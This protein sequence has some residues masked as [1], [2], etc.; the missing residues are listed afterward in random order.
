MLYLLD[1]CVLITANNTYYPIDQVPE[2]WDWLL[3]QSS[4]GRIKM[5]VE[6]LEEVLN[7]K[8]ESD[9]LVSWLSSCEYKTKLLLPNEEVNLELVRRVI[10]RGYAA[11]LNDIEIEILGRDPFLIAYALAE[12]DR[13]IVTT[14]ASKPSKQRQNKRLPDVCNHLG[15]K[16]CDTF[17]L[18]RE[19]GF[20]TAWRTAANLFSP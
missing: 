8:K 2:F 19:L 1:A 17:T 3:H 13:C 18:N 15:V 16:W 12:P 11:D 6:T 5:P 4:L 7:G 10:E 9:K 20:R 14:E